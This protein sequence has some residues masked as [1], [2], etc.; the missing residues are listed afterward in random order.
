LNGRK[1]G[2]RQLFGGNLVRQPAYEGLKYRVV[3]DLENSDRVMNQAFWIGV[4]P[5][6]TQA[7]LDYVLESIN[8]IAL[9]GVLSDAAGK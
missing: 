6:L 9:K 2:T 1:I 3:G 7:M 4:Y 5:G 8:E